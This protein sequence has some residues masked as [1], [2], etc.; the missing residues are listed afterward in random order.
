MIALALGCSG[1]RQSHAPLTMSDPHAVRYRLRL[2]DNPVDPGEA[3]RCYGRCQSEVTARGY[4]ECL[5]ACP[6]F[7]ETPGMRCDVTEVPPETACFTVRKLPA[8]QAIPT[9]MVVLAVVADVALVVALT[10]L[11]AS[12][13]HECGYYYPAPH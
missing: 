9:D 10:S 7:E 2:R 11:C 6:G 1:Q 8:T 4:F 13:S 12:S 3:F 5:R